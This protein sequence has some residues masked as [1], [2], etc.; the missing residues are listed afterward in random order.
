MDHISSEEV[1]QPGSSVNWG[2]ACHHKKGPCDGVKD[3]SG[4]FMEEKAA[5]KEQSS[6]NPLG[7]GKQNM[8]DNSPSC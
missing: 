1:T 2:W 7:K 3:M 8:N 6:S 4:H 5:E